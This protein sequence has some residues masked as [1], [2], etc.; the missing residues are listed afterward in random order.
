MEH[1]DQTGT[2]RRLAAIMF[3]DIAGFTAISAENEEEAL[4]LIDRQREVLQP[5]V[6]QYNGRWLKEMGDGLLLS[7]PSSKQAVS[8]AIAIQEAVKEIEGLRL[9]IGVHQGDILVKDTDVFGDDVNIASRIEP[10]AAPGGIA[11]SDKIHRDISGSP[12]FATK[13]VGRPKLKGVKQEVKVFCIVSHGLPQTRLSDVSA[14]LQR[15]S[16]SRLLWI[17]PALVILGAAAYLFYPEEETVPSLGVLRFENLGGKEDEFWARGITE[18][19]I[20]EVASAGMIRVAPLN[21]IVRFVDTDLSLDEIARRLGVTYLLVSTIH[22]MDDVFDLRTQLIEAETG[23]SLLAKKWSEPVGRASMIT[24]TLAESILSELGVSTRR[25]MGKPSTEHAEVYELY[26]RGK[27]IYKGRQGPE[28]VKK[29]RRLLR[30]AI[31]LDPH[32]PKARIDLG[33]TYF[34]EGQFDSAMSVYQG[35]LLQCEKLGD[36]WGLGTSLV[37]IGEV[38]REKGETDKALDHFRQAVNLHRKVGDLRQVANSLN[39]MGIIYAG[40]GEFK[41]ALDS[42]GQALS[43][44]QQLGDLEGIAVSLNNLGHTYLLRGEFDRSISA[45]ERALEI[46]R[47]QEKKSS[48]AYCLSH[49]ANTYYVKGEYDKSFA[50]YEKA[51]GIKQEVKDSRGAAI[52]LQMMGQ[53]SFHLDRFDQSSQ[54][55]E[56]ASAIWEELQDDKGQLWTLSWWALSEL[57]SDRRESARRKMER[58]DKILRFEEPGEGEIITVNWNLYLLHSAFGN[59]LAARRFLELAHHEITA[60]AER[61]QDE[62]DRE[63]FLKGVREN[64]VVLEAWNPRRGK[65]S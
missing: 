31:E 20:I 27:Y 26:L 8:C 48:V 52:A 51:L 44:R 56:G 10:F 29:A 55:F 1:L 12:E 43:I 35:C 39:N 59:E 36:K 25:N 28:D 23:Q 47:E 7:F 33:L 41:N 15:G 53:A 5:I 30:K 9:R 2:V 37:K 16:T 3:T 64:R 34:E 21:E 58:L 60:R 4:A 40:R 57:K 38:L 62:H 61:I 11:I 63:F 49:I 13:Y 14:K 24:G 6:H 32:L 50:F 65:I 18:D 17:L 22:R 42:Y 45:H 46:R 19:L 54:H